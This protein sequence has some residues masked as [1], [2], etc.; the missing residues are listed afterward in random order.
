MLPLGG[1]L[2]TYNKCVSDVMLQYLRRPC[3]GDVSKTVTMNASQILSMMELLSKI[4][5]M[6]S[7][8]LAKKYV[9]KHLL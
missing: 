8:I 9:S 6:R 4:I 1:S 2:P 3:Y 5:L 7:T